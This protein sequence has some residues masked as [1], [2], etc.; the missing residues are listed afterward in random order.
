M[1]N[2]ISESHLNYRPDIDGLRAIAVTSVVIYHSFPRYFPG[3]FAGVDVFFV[4]S[5]F[6][7]STIIL[8]QIQSKTFSI[9]DFYQ[10]RALRIFPSLITVL[11]STAAIG[12]FSLKANEFAQLGK[13]IA[14]GA[15]FVSNLLLWTELG[16]FDAAAETKPLLHLWS[17]GIEEQFY[18]IFPLLLLISYKIRHR[19]LGTIVFVASLSFV[20]N[21]YYLNTE[22]NAIFYSP[23]SRFWEMMIGSTL[24]YLLLKQSSNL[25]MIGL[26]P[27]TRSVLGIILLVGGFWGASEA[28]AYPGWWA[29]LPTFAAALLIS[30]GPN[31]FINRQVLSHKILVKLGLLSYPLYLWHW[32]L[33]ALARV[34]YGQTPS[35]LVRAL[36]VVSSVLLAWLTYRLVERPLRFN[37]HKKA[38]AIG[39]TTALAVTGVFGVS[40]FLADGIK[41]R[42]INNVPV[43]YKG[44]INH[45][46]FHSYVNKNFF[47]CGPENIFE[48]AEKWEAEVR[49]SQS[50]QGGARQVALV[51]DSHSEHL[52]IG[53][54]E[55]LRDKNVVFYI[56]NDQIGINNPVYRDILDEVMTNKSITTVVVSSYWLQR[57]IQIEELRMTLQELAGNDRKVFITDDVPNFSF[58][59]ALCKF[60]GNCTEVGFKDRYA[61]YINTLKSVVL[62]VPSVTLIESASY[63]C[64]KEVCF[65]GRDGV[66]YYRDNN[67][68]NIN[69][70]KLIGQMIA[71]NYPELS[72]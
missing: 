53:L 41:T 21:I 47:P 39:L 71:K 32:P 43:A 70:S 40:I 10:R 20:C 23:I 44:D 33:L 72:K 66:L 16:Y 13:H 55:A 12:W 51:G 29:L 24:A 15:G 2:S 60:Q 1:S 38:T 18:F 59:P 22:S 69:G 8:K 36:C 14:G 61:S 35:S 4:I 19:I 17:L 50:K 46:D 62:E 63:L 11:V 27:K 9:V 5:G 37:K 42:S 3:G 57:G 64:D 34:H 68:L 54:S 30:S 6:L 49:C 45:I 25:K 26:D 67:H 65:M 52:F 58:D 31:T 28:S 48:V 56:K 7:I